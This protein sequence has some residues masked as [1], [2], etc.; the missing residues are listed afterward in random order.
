MLNSRSLG[1]GGVILLPYKMGTPK[2]L[3]NTAIYQYIVH[4]IRKV[5][6]C[7]FHYAEIYGTNQN[8][9]CKFEL[10]RSENQEK[11]FR[12]LLSNAICLMTIATIIS[13]SA[14]RK[15]IS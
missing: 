6:S 8:I 13:E 12:A 1:C 15:H 14:Q 5:S 11:K 7:S 9:Q 4:V 10:P 3:A 2:M